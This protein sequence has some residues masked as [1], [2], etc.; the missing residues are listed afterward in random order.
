MEYKTPSFSRVDLM[1]EHCMCCLVAAGSDCQIGS[2]VTNPF[3][4]IV[5]YE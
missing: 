4:P 1:V 5:L 2:P 3:G